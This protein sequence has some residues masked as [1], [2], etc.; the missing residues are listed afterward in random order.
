MDKLGL[1]RTNDN[2]VGCNK[3]ISVCSCMGAMTAD[4]K[5]GQQNIIKVDGDK[6][7]ACGACFDACEH[8]AREFVDDTERFFA[9]LKKGESISILIAPAFL[10]NFPKSTKACLAGSRAS[11]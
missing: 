9:D 5:D 11:A 10:A 4:M 8:N 3:C 7:V 1:V 2:C 6:C